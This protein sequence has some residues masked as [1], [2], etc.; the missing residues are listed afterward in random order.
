MDMEE[1]NKGGNT[2]EGNMEEGN[3]EV[4]NIFCFL[5]A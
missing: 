4:G 3:K 5:L 1:G 2:V